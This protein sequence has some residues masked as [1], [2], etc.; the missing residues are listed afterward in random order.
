[1]GASTSDVYG[2]AHIPVM[3]GRLVM[4]MIRGFAPPQVGIIKFTQGDFSVYLEAYRSMERSVFAISPRSNI[5]QHFGNGVALIP[6]NLGLSMV[7]NPQNMAEEFCEHGSLF[8]VEYSEDFVYPFSVYVASILLNTTYER[9]LYE[10]S[11]TSE[12]DI[13]PTV[14]VQQLLN[15][16]IPNRTT[17]IIPE[18]I[19]N[20]NIENY[21]SI[22]F[23]FEQRDGNTGNF[24]SKGDI[25]YA[26]DDYLQV[27]DNGRCRLMIRAGLDFQFGINFLKRIASHHK[28]TQIGF[29]DP[30]I[31]L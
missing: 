21:A 17:Q 30:K 5:H 2:L 4:G 15:S 25:E 12:F 20:C 28:T 9:R 22:H 26:P 18:Y 6:T 3:T 31:V 23:R 27:S 11:S 29:C 24:L 13:L 8:Y 1:M 7:V 10:F 16:I 14:I 19:E